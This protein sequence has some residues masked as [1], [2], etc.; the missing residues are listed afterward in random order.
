MNQKKNAN[1]FY[2]PK[3]TKNISKNISPSMKSKLFKKVINERKNNDRNTYNSIINNKNK[4][5]KLGEN[6][7]STKMIKE[8][9]RE[10]LILKIKKINVQ[11]ENNIK[12]IQNNQID[13]Y[14]KINNQ[15]K[16]VKNNLNDENLKVEQ[17]NKDSNEIKNSDTEKPED[18]RDY[19]N[20][21]GNEFDN[22]YKNNDGKITNE[23]IEEVEEA[24]E[25]S[26]LKQPSEIMSF[27]SNS[28]LS[29]SNIKNY[30][31]IQN[32]ISKLKKNEFIKYER[33]NL[34]TECIQILINKKIKKNI[35][36]QLP[37]K[38]IEIGFKKTKNS[39]RNNRKKDVGLNN[40]NN[41]MLTKNNNLTRVN[42][43]KN[44][45]SKRKMNNKKIISEDKDKGINKSIDHF[46]NTSY[47]YLN[48]DKIRLKINKIKNKEE[49]YH[50]LLEDYNS[51]E[52]KNKNRVFVKE[53]LINTRK[54][55]K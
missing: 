13:N 10:K 4:K 35:N 48:L 46:Y 19:L 1:D 7:F 33:I 3:N 41:L 47:T 27:H 51:R 5:I 43:N 12:K 22:N 17:N 53:A 38:R 20:I 45:T 11:K 9:T 31:S 14:L 28:K 26:E 16:V 23:A 36:H 42:Y 37:L 54:Y 6:I 34:K 52:E 18:I 2:K 44:N 30:E 8:H 39:V 24:K 55:K 50:K 21:E 40:E 29:K 15:N 49:R 25:M 32:N